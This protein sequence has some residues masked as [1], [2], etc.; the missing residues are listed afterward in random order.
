M[1]KNRRYKLNQIL[2]ILHILYDMSFTVNQ[3]MTKSILWSLLNEKMHFN[4]MR[5]ETCPY[6]GQN[7]VGTYIQRYAF[8]TEVIK[9]CESCH[10]GTQRQIQHVDYASSYARHNATATDDITADSTLVI[11]LLLLIYNKS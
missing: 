10:R 9:K 5:S 2:H 7:R 6:C 3:Q 8:H 1:S 4:P 11:Y